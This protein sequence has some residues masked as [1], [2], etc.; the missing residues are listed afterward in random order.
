MKR[1][2]RE[3][4][5]VFLSHRTTGRDVPRDLRLSLVC[6]SS[7]LRLSFPLRA[8]FAF[9][10]GASLIIAYLCNRFFTERESGLY[11][12]TK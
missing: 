7:V 11:N 6:L 4:Q 9:S 12:N 3:T 10:F 1:E 8:F 2:T 5:R